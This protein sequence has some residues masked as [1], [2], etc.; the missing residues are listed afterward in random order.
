MLYLSISGMV[1]DCHGNLPDCPLASWALEQLEHMH[2]LA[3]WRAMIVRS[4]GAEIVDM[5]EM[6]CT[7]KAWADWLAC[8][9]E[10]AVGDRAAVEASA[11][12]LLDTLAIVL[13]KL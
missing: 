1:R 4:N 6:G 13:R 11:L 8:D 12:E 5:H 3:W 10:Y 2:D 7:R 9:N